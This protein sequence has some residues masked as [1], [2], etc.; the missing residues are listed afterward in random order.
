LTEPAQGSLKIAFATSRVHERD[1]VSYWREEAT[2]AYV[3]HEFTTEAGRA[4]HGVIRTGKLADLALSQFSCSPCLVEH[5]AQSVRGALDD[6]LIVTLVKDGRTVVRQDGRDGV[7]S[8]GQ[9]FIVDPRRPFSL[10]IGEDNCTL[11]L[12]VPRTELSARLGDISVLTARPLGNKAEAVLAA[13]FL[14]MLA[15]RAELLGEPAASKVAKQALDLMALAFEAEA[16][17][18][19]SL[20]SS[21]RATTLLR[22]KAVIEPRLADPSLRPQGAAQAA[23]ISVRYANSLLAEEGTSLE[24][25]IMARRLRHCREALGDPAQAQRTVGDIAFSWGFSD[26]SHFTRRFKT[27]FGCSPSEWRVRALEPVR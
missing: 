5:T 18:A 11:V 23:G 14:A 2:R 16:P 8:I 19:R 22:L 9:L 1:R 26:V 4:F 24:R 10:D 17:G 6:N 20:Q 27:E 21:T 7:A 13:K 3:A 25:F 15:D 12:R